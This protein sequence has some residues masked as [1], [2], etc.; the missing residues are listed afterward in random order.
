VAACAGFRRARLFGVLD[1]VVNPPHFACV[2][3]ADATRGIG[4]GNGLP[5]PKLPTDV[6]HFKQITTR[7]RDAAARNAVIMGRKTWD[8]LPPR[9]R[10]LDGRVNV[11]VSRGAPLLPEGV[12]LARDLDDAIT[13]AM[14]AAVESIFV[15]GGAQIY[16][17]AFRDPRC[18]VIYYTDVRGTFATDAT[19]PAPSESGFVLEAA[20]DVIRDAPVEYVIQ[21][22]RRR[23]GT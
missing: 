18:E 10:P 3:A 13:Q 11:I 17:E 1:V 4:V 16:A 15:V 9:W 19:I 8:T 7:T 20:S 12:V 14:T 5:W 2:V 22:F 23:P 21:R 6:E